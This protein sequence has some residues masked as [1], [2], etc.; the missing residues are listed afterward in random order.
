[1]DHTDVSSESIYKELQNSEDGNK[2][3][4]I[5]FVSRYEMLHML[6]NWLEW[7]KTCGT[8]FGQI[9]DPSL[10]RMKLPK[11]QSIVSDSSQRFQ[12]SSNSQGKN[13]RENVS[14]K[15]ALLKTEQ[16]SDF[17]QESNSEHVDGKVSSAKSSALVN[18]VTSH[19]RTKLKT[20]SLSNAWLK[21][22][23]PKDYIDFNQFS[24]APN[25]LQNIDLWVKNNSLKH[26]T[27][28]STCVVT[29]GIWDADVLLIEGHASSLSRE[30]LDMLKK[31]RERVLLIHGKQFFWLPFPRCNDCR[32]CRSI[33]KAKLNAVQPKIVLLMGSTPLPFLRFEGNVPEVGESSKIKMAHGAIPIFRSYHPMTLLEEPNRKSRAF[34]QLQ[35]FHQTLYQMQIVPRENLPRY[36]RSSNK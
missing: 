12:M 3:D 17:S 16:K 31:M 5:N 11:S 22:A 29:K 1:M 24:P 20:K 33:F 8:E 36:K 30:G 32:G 14:K 6:E 27:K 21:A 34:Q 4:N 2:K 18:R 28:P 7:Q 25:T 15:T 13:L 10:L 19:H 9:T 35:H 23:K 26:N